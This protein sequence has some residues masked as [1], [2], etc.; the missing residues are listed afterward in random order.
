MDGQDRSIT[1]VLKIEGHLGAIGADH[2]GKPQTAMDIA[3]TVQGAIA[4]GYHAAN[5]IN[6][7]CFTESRIR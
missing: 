2:Q 1:C 4:I 5:E 7:P 6:Q 3:G